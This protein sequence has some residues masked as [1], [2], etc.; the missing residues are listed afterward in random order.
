MV[1]SVSHR[2]LCADA[3]GLADKSNTN[4][5]SMDMM[6]DMGHTRVCGYLWYPELR[7]IE[8]VD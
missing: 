5:Q 8:R 7:I 2:M 4:N 3:T 6:R 1:C